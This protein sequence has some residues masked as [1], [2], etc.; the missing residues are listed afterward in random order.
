MKLGLGTA[1]F[2]SNYGISNTFGQTRLDE[3]F[4]ILEFAASV[5]IKVLDT[6]Y[7]YG[8]SEQVLGKCLSGDHKFQI[9]TKTPKFSDEEIARDDARM[10]EEAFQQSLFRMGQKSVYGLLLHDA[11]NLLCDHGGLLIERMLD[12]KQR[13]LVRKIGISV[14]SAQQIDRILDK[15]QVDLVQVPVSV[16]DQRLLISGRLFRLKQAGVEIHARS[17]FLQG[18]LLMDPETLPPHFDSVRNHLRSYHR[19]I[20]ERGLSPVEASLGFVMGIEEIDCVICGVNNHLQL[21][22]NCYQARP[23]TREGFAKFAIADTVILNPAQ[24]RL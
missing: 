3:A 10:L 23:L 18:T 9:V 12:L 4:K 8:D 17:A 6:A 11:N 5:G 21:Q 14:S 15:Y 20:R 24:W 7:L 22:E 13:G 19:A 1:Q 2:G 16:L